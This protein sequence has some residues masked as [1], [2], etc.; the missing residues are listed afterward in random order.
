MR[1]LVIM[2]TLHSSSENQKSEIKKSFLPDSDFSI[3][4][5]CNTENELDLNQNHETNHEEN[6][7]V[8]R[9]SFNSIP[10][11]TFVSYQA[12]K[13]KT[14][15]KKRSNSD[16]KKQVEDT[17]QNSSTSLLS[18]STSS[19]SSIAIDSKIDSKIDVNLE[20]REHHPANK[21]EWFGSLSF[22]RQSSSSLNKES[23]IKET[24]E[25]NYEKNHH[26]SSVNRFTKSTGKLVTDGFVGSFRKS[27]KRILIVF[28]MLISLSIF[29]MVQ[30]IA[31]SRQTNGSSNIS[32]KIPFESFVSL[33][34][35]DFAIELESNLPENLLS[36][37]KLSSNLDPVSEKNIDSKNKEQLNAP[38]NSLNQSTNSSSSLL[39]KQSAEKSVSGSIGNS[40]PRKPVLPEDKNASSITKS[41]NPVV[42]PNPIVP[43]PPGIQPSPPKQEAPKQ[44]APQEQPLIA[45]NDTPPEEKMVEEPNH[46][47]DIDLDHK[48]DQCDV[49]Q[50]GTKINFISD[51]IVA[52]KK[53]KKENKPIFIMH[54]AGNFEDDAFT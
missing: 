49:Q 54:I 35:P 16:R 43:V 48:K 6:R 45:Q 8:T 50:Y 29:A 52:F 15:A 28:T 39:P 46:L 40:N 51:P 30:I 2:K 36:K 34:N 38:A 20:E 12:P 21:S 33:A 47:L 18:S 1:D 37:I 31:D 44:E 3:N 42:Q 9:E 25:N 11:A 17:L 4:I 53:A 24:S 5:Q 23:L 27:W 19:K 41:P 26:Q 10:T 22:H 32:S 13:T 7:I 14:K